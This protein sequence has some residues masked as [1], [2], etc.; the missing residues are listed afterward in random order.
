VTLDH[1]SADGDYTP[2]AVNGSGDLYVIDTEA[3]LKLADIETAVQLLDDIVYNEDSA[4]TTADP[5]AFVLA[6]RNDTRGTLV[7]ADGDYSP[8]A[9]NG[10]GDLYVIDTAGNV[11]LSAI[12]T[13]VELIDNL[14]HLE[15]S[16]HVTGDAGLMPLG[17]RQDTVSPLAADGDY[18]PFSMDRNGSLRVTVTDPNASATEV[19]DYQTEVDLASGSPISHDYTV[20]ALKTLLLKQVWATASG[21]IKVEVI[22]DPSGTPLTKFVGFNSTANPNIEIPFYDLIEVAAG[23]VVRVQ[24]TNLDNKAQDVYSTLL[25]NEI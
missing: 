2:F 13:S 21:R 19:D 15:D 1:L 10:S 11:I 23:L 17:V 4:H 20:T 14:V 5:G 24:I 3:N 6:V 8:F 12:K 25:G 9:V 18:I 22:I 16:V 7:S